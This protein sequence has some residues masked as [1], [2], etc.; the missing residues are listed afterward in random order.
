MPYR[1]KHE[2]CTSRP[3]LA[4]RS[5]LHLVPEP[6]GIKP[7]EEDIE[8]LDICARELRDTGLGFFEI[9]GEGGFELRGAVANKTF[10]DNQ[11]LQVFADLGF[12]DVASESL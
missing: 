11:F 8:N 9:R 2:T 6:L 1:R 7:V 3:T 10:M 4:I 12:H 5:C